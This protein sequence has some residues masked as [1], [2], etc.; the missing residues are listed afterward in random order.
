MLWQKR[1][2]EIIPAAMQFAAKTAEQK[3]VNKIRAGGAR[4]ME[5]GVQ[6]QSAS[7]VKPDVSQLS[8][9]DRAEIIRRAERGEKIRF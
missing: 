4:P 1:K 3:V 6:D 9:A 8:K 7:L 5:N 2:D